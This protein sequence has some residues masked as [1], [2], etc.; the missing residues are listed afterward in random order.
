MLTGPLPNTLDVR[1]A[2]TRELKVEGTLKPLDL[3]RFGALLASDEGRIQVA[4]VFSRD[5][6]QRSVVQ[7]DIDAQVKVVCQRCLQ[8]MHLDIKADNTL[9][10]VWND[11]QARLLP[12]DLEALIVEE[13]C[14]LWDVVEEEL[15]LALPQFSYH[16]QTE[17]EIDLADFSHAPLP[18]APSEKSNPFDVLAQLKPGKEE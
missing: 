5:E 15:I 10:V 12:R 8:P 1:K 17:C 11:E 9:A 2:A 13:D 14:L 4:M 18:E 7:V 16:E 3:Q 6:E